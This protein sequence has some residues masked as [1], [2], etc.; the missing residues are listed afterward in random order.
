M[1][2]L[3]L[4]LP[5]AFVTHDILQILVRLDIILSHDACRIVYHFFGQAYLAG[6]LY[7]KRRARTAYLKLEQCSHFVSVVEHCTVDRPLVSI[8]KVLQVLVMCGDDCTHSLCPKL[9]QDRFG[10]RSSYLRLCSRAELINEYERPFRRTFHH[11]F[12][13][14]QVGRVGR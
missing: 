5:V 13:V 14:P 11:D 8:G 2:G 12:H 6:Y 7:G 9:L 1:N 4:R 10:N 3:S